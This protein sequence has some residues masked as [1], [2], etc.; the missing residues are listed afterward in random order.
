MKSVKKYIIKEEEYV[1]DREAL[2]SALRDVSKRNKITKEKLIDELVEKDVS[3]RDTIKN[4]QYGKSSPASKEE[5]LNIADALDIDEM[6]LLKKCGGEEKVERLN[7][8]QLAAAKRIYDIAIW[9]LEEFNNT[10]GFTSIEVDYRAA[11]YDDPKEARADRVDEMRRKVDL[12][13]SQEYFDLHDHEIYD[14]FCE[15]AA[16]D[17]LDIYNGKLDFGYRFGAHPEGSHPTVWDDYEKAMQHLNQIV[18]RYY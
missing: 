8:R 2:K 7:E 14:D 16:E 17:L 12:V 11:G 6:R 13:I 1:F 15:F 3:T 4:W 9:F 10:D 18:E 5:I